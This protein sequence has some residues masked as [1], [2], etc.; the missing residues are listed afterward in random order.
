MC[1]A[2]HDV[3]V[4]DRVHRT[5]TRFL[6]F[7]DKEDIMKVF[8]GRRKETPLRKSKAPCKSKGA[9]ILKSAEEESQSSDSQG[10]GI[11][12][13]RIGIEPQRIGTNLQGSGK[14]SQSNEAWERCENARE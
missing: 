2:P 3:H 1:I 8:L 9:G 12:P 14:E 5:T 4:E 6:M 7:A 13:Q 11:E 10:S